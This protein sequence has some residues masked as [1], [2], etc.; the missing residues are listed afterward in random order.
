MMV[1]QMKLICDAASKYV[2]AAV[3]FEWIH[4]LLSHT[5]IGATTPRTIPEW[6][7]LNNPLINI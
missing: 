7:Y 3:V 2:K 6:V 1:V 4:Q 5:P